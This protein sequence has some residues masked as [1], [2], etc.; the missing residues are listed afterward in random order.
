MSWL[1]EYCAAAE[2]TDQLA[3]KSDHAVVGNCVAHEVNRS[4]GSLVV[5]SSYASLNGTKGR[6]RTL[7]NEIHTNTDPEEAK[8][9]LAH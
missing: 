9:V 7:L 3:G 6:M 4:V 5:H 2:R 1:T 8:D